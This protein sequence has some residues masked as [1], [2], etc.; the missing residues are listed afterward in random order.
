MLLSIVLVSL[1]DR[2]L[3]QQSTSSQN[4]AGEEYK[5]PQS[6]KIAYSLGLSPEHP[7]NFG[8]L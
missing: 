7:Q 5:S 6:S 4:K 8:S 1:L 3:P 2:A